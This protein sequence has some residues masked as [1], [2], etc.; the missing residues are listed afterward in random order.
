MRSIKIEK[1]CHVVIF[2]NSLFFM[3]HYSKAVV[4]DYLSAYCFKLQL[5][6]RPAAHLEWD[7]N[8]AVRR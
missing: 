2:T 6:E 1:K 5:M 3:S 4:I 7:K 8:K